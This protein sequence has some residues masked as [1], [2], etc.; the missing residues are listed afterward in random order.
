MMTY[1]H[2]GL[3][4]PSGMLYVVFDRRPSQLAKPSFEDVF[5]V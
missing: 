4:D 5:S 3:F 2:D 1:V